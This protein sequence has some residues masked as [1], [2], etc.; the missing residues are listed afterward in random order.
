MSNEVSLTKRNIKKLNSI[1]GYWC[2]TTLLYLTH[3]TQALLLNNETL[4]IEEYFKTSIF[5]FKRVNNE[6][7]KFL[8]PSMRVSKLINKQSSI[9]PDSPGKDH[10]VMGEVINLLLLTVL[11]IQHG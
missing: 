2:S 11:S 6:R 10:M 9:E 4:I 8:M 7:Y 3:F 5:T 1:S